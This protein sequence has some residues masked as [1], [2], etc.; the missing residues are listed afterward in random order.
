MHFSFT[1]QDSLS[2]WYHIVKLVSLLLSV[3]FLLSPFL[4]E[5]LSLRNGGVTETIKVTW[6]QS[7]LLCVAIKLTVHTLFTNTLDAHLIEILLSL[8]LLPYPYYTG[9]PQKRLLNH[10]VVVTQSVVA[11]MRTFSCHGSP[12]LGIVF[13][14]LNFANYTPDR[15]TIIYVVFM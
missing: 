7:R 9:R 6:S 4:V 14:P 11:K 15:L 12:V 5:L 3:S 1:I 8:G 10:Q 2:L 13:L